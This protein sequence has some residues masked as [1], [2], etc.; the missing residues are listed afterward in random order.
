MFGCGMP[1]YSPI[2]LFNAKEL[3]ITSNDSLSVIDIYLSIDKETKEDLLTLLCDLR[4][5][6]CFPF[7]TKLYK[8]DNEIVKKMC[9]CD[10]LTIEKNKLKEKFSDGDSLNIMIVSRVKNKGITFVST[11]TIYLNENNPLQRIKAD[12]FY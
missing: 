2:F 5:D 4:E 10:T 6:D 11:S 12:S 8:K 9:K 3:T 1:E 7:K